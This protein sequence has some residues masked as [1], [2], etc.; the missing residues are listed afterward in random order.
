MDFPGAEIA[1]HAL[2]YAQES[3]RRAGTAIVSLPLP[4][5]P[6][7]RTPQLLVAPT[8]LRIA[9]PLEGEDILTGRFAFAGELVLAEGRPVFSC[10]MPSEGFEKILSG[11]G[12]LRHLR[13]QRGTEA[14]DFARAAVLSFLRR[15]RS[16][17]GPSWTTEV[18]ATRL[19]AWL[20]HSTVILK[21]ADAGFYR[22]FIDAVTRHE[23]V[24][25]RRFHV[26]A[27]DEL[28]LQVAMTLAM[29]SISLD[30]S[31]RYKR[32]ARLRLDTELVR[33]ILP[34]GGHI[35]R[36]P[37]ALL[38]LLLGLLP[39]RQT[40][41]NLEQTLPKNLLASIDRAYAALNFF[42]HSDG[43]LALFNGAGRV[44][45]TALSALLRYDEIGSA[46]FKALPHTGFQRLEAGGTVLIADAGKPLGA[47]LSKTAH[48]G[49]AAFEL[50]SGKNRFI[51]NAGVPLARDSEAA[52]MARST[53][54]HSAAS[55]DD[56]SSLRFSKSPFLGPVAFGGIRHVAVSRDHDE[57]GHDR[58]VI[59][60]DGYL[61]RFSLYA[62]RSLALSPD[63]R[64]LSGIDRFRS[65]QDAAPRGDHVATIRF[66]LHPAIWTMQEDADT[67]FM[68]APDNESWL[69]TAT[70]L[71]PRLEDGIYFAASTGARQARQ[72]VIEA[73]IAEH[74]EI[75]W[76]FKRL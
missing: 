43:E 24:L 37:D 18:T 53:A 63:G 49:T 71:A 55:I 8:D 27:R 66:H 40:Y 11:F 68:T 51:V 69:F 62:E 32:V 56:H 19:N 50:S 67:I 16:A 1:R 5:W 14:N 28:R 6:G 17:T 36:N 59:R 61:S 41:I 64:E 45:S 21:G 35:S 70:G 42:R 54:A 46:G 58:I 7:G 52:R 60:H 48:A 26:M 29:V 20:C 25:R 9:D 4:R 75:G 74:A 44:P 13:T 57:R 33:Q 39:L 73:D 15:H 30:L 31:E 10:E 12:W 22:R 65:R 47:A 2:L 3:L 34:D 23:L 38:R 76:Q 72:I